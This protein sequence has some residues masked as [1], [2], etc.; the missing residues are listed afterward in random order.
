MVWNPRHPVWGPM[1]VATGKT[2]LQPGAKREENWK[3]TTG[4]LWQGVSRFGTQQRELRTGC[5][6][7]KRRVDAGVPIIIYLINTTLP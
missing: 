6:L 2:R 1:F 7:M 5:D 4:N 3:R